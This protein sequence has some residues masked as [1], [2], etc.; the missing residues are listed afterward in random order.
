MNPRPVDV[1]PM[2]DYR[3]LVT[4]Q[5]KEQ[6]VFDVSVLLELPMYYKL[7]NKGFFSLAK[8]DGMCVYW[9]DEI[10]ICPDMTYEDSVPY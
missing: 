9:N 3:L 7:K 10:D 4:F 6:K 8:A 5:N 2:E 1:Q